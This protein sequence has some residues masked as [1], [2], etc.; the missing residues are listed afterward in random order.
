MP[1]A[2]ELIDDHWRLAVG[3]LSVHL[4]GRDAVV[5]PDYSDPTPEV[6][7]TIDIAAPRDVVF[8]ALVEPA[9]VNQWFGAKSA[10]I[11][12]RAGGRYDLG[13]KYKVDGQDVDGGPTS[14]VDIVTNETLVLAWPDWRGDTSVTGQTISFQLESVGAGTRLTFVHAGFGRTTDM[15]DYGFGWKYFM[16]NLVKLLTSPESMPEAESVAEHSSPT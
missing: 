8:R 16:G 9:L 2:R 7:L 15:G 5:L 12:P 10:I 3:N 14:I 11:E 13:W 6:R 4:A 1:R